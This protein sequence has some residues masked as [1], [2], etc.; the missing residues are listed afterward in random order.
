M[1][2]FQNHAHYLKIFILIFSFSLFGCNQSASDLG[3]TPE[4]VAIEFFEALYNQKDLDKAVTYTTPKIK[5]IMLH[6]KTAS[7]VQRHVLNMKYDQV[8][9]EIDK[10]GR[11][12]PLIEKTAKSA[13]VTLFF[14]GH[15]DGRKMKDLK[16]VEM[17]KQADGWKVKKIKS[18]PYAS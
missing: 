5:R 7:A 12:Q 6:Y 14:S 4:E 2:P 16:T 17:T 18:D 11:G 15:Y 1:S 10:T 9:I 13:K 3:P 8:V